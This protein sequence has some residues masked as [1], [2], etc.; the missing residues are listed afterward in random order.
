MNE[1]IKA[2]FDRRSIRKFKPDRLTDEQIE[3][4]IQVAL[5]SPSGMDLQPWLFHFITNQDKI[6]RI[7]EAVLE[8]F[9]KAG[10][11]A[12]LDRMAARHPSIFY[13]APLL[14]VISMPQDNLSGVDAGIAIENLAIAAQSMGLGSCIIGMAAAGF[15]GDE[16]DELASL[17][18]MPADHAFM[19][20]IAIGHPAMTKEAHIRNRKKIKV[21]D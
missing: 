15:N 4:L 11:Q 12:L 17:I 21:I 8:T 16:G 6:S 20:S 10:N 5:A 7:S 13:G 18:E 3:T 19:I 14:V 9:R 2:I 1:T